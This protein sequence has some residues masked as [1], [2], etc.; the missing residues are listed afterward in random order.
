[1]TITSREI[2]IGKQ[3]STLRA[4]LLGFLAR[5][6][7]GARAVSDALLGDRALQDFGASPADARAEGDKPFWRA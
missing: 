4:S 7:N 2:C 6:A 3:T 1:M 5:I